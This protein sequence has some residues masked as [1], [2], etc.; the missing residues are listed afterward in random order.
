MVTNEEMNSHVQSV[1][2]DLRQMVQDERDRA[3][4]YKNECEKKQRKIEYLWF[5]VHELEEELL[6]Y[7]RYVP[8][9]IDRG[10][11]KYHADKED[12]I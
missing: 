5:R 6:Q 9:E 3:D 4:R 8:D 12:G 7:R 11:E 10:C 2:N 1:I